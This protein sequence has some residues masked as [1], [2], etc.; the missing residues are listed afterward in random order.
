MQF[1]LW[2]SCPPSVCLVTHDRNVMNH[3]FL[4]SK[5]L[6]QRKAEATDAEIDDDHKR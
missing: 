5:R 6:S 3:R 1:S 2:I 4:Q